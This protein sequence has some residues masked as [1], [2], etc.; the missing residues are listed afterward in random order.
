MAGFVTE[1]I[2]IIFY[3][4]WCS[5]ELDWG[6]KSLICEKFSIRAISLENLEARQTREF[7]STSTRWQLSSPPSCAKIY[8]LWLGRTGPLK[9]IF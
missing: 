2:V 3:K 6:E 1:E 5:L 9:L 8:F 4:D 7:N